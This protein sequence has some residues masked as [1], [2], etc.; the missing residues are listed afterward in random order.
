MGILT[1]WSLLSMFV[2]KGV[3]SCMLIAL[4]GSAIANFRAFHEPQD[5]M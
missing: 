2:I 1:D 4:I 3:I 5:D